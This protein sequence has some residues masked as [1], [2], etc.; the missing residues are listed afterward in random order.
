MAWAKIGNIKGPG[1][2]VNLGTVTLGQTATLAI[3]A[4]IRTIS[5]NV[6]G[7]LAAENVLLQPITA[8]PSGYLV[9][10]PTA[11]AGA[12]DVPIYAPAMVINASYSFQARVLAIR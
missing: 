7:L 6:T 1:S 2:I 10:L 11:R 9:G 12:L 3:A 4:G 5:A 8:L